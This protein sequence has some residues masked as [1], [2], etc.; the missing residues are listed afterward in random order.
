MVVLPLV[1][2][3]AVALLVWNQPDTLLRFTAWLE[4]RSQQLFYIS[5]A[6]A[7]AKSAAT[8]AYREEWSRHFNTETQESETLVQFGVEVFNEEGV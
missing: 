1:I 5:R 6:R 3:A 2:I 4:K 7:A 8:T